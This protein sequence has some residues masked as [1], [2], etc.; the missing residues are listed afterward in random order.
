MHNQLQPAV[1]YDDEIDLRELFTALWLY[2]RLI[3]IITATTT[4]LALIYALLTPNQYQATAV[5]APTQQDGG[6]LSAA[7]SQFGGLASLAG[8]N[9]VD[10]KGNEVR[11]AQQ[12]M[13]S[14]S[15]IEQFIKQSGIAVEVMAVKGWDANADRLIIDSDIYSSTNR[16]WT[17]TPPK[18]RAAEPSPWE[19][20]EVFEEMLSVSEDK[21][22]GFVTVS[23]EYFSPYLAKQWVDN[24]ILAV[25]LYLQ[26][27]KLRRINKNI[28][29]LE[30]QIEITSVAEMR[31]IFFTLIEE[32]IKSKMLVEASPDY[33]FI[34]VSEAMVPEEKSQPKRG[35]IVILA[36]L[37]GIML[38]V[39]MA[40]MQ[41]Y[42]FNRNS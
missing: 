26:Q 6:G 39:A 31:Q 9:L 15:F 27:R 14:R 36:A 13:Q 40:L 11:I 37:L 20:Y 18:G 7:L 2:R 3:G 25:N 23:I 5:L 30:E 32:Q 12:V 17:R 38:S 42:W 22:S 16:Q 10:S 4:I 41:F 8:I 24:Y 21:K 33:A 1:T 29:Y 34:T 19:L 35:L 28:Q